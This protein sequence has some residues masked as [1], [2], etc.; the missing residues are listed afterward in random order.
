MTVWIK[1]K[2]LYHRSAMVE[3]KQRRML[4][5]GFE[6]DK[7]EALSIQRELKQ[8]YIDDMKKKNEE[9]TMSMLMH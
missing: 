1:H 8:K 2:L 4:F 5:A 9:V 7:A 6:E 3:T